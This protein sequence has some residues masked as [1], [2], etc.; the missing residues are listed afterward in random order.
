MV[1]SARC[2]A[3]PHSSRSRLHSATAGLRVA[4]EQRQLSSAPSAAPLSPSV[5]L[6]RSMLSTQHLL[7]PHS[8]D[9]PSNS[10][11]ARPRGGNTDHKQHHQDRQPCHQSPTTPSQHGECLAPQQPVHQQRPRVE[12]LPRVLTGSTYSWYWYANGIT[13]CRHTPPPPLYKV[14]KVPLPTL[15]TR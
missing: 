2:E 15:S 12:G 11:R 7:G 10:P 14:L 9:L 8:R 13:S 5:F 1:R 3:S 4:D 6:I